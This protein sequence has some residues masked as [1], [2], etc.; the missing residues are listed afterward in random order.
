MTIADGER[1]PAIGDYGIV[2]DSR[3]CALVSRD[4]SIDW[5]CAPNFDSPSLFGRLLDWERGGFFRIAPVGPYEVRRGYISDTNVLETTF[6]A[7]GGAVA[8]IDFMPALTEDEKRATL[9]PLRAVLRIVEGRH[10]RVPMRMVY[11]PRS[12]YGRR[13]PNLRAHSLFEVTAS[14]GRDAVHLR[15]DVPLE[16]TQESASARFDAVAG[17]R[18]RFSLAYSEGEPGVILS[19]GYVDATFERTVAFWRDWSAGCTY[20]GPYRDN[21]VRSAL[22]LKLLSYAPSGAIVAAAT[23]SLPEGIGGAR[24]WD[25]RYCWLRDASFTIKAFL[26]LGLKREAEA[27]TGWLMHATRQSAPSLS[28]MYTLTGEPHIPERELRDLEGYRRSAP[29]RI[30]NAASGQHQFDVYGELIDAFH[31]YVR[32]TGD[33]VSADAASFVRRVADHV[34]EIWREPDSGIWEPRIAPL[35]YTHSKVMAWSALQHA[36]ALAEEGCIRGDAPRWRREAEEIRRTVMERGFNH[37][38]GAFTQTLDG[39]AVDAALLTL[40]LVEF[41]RPNDPQML[42]TITAIQSELSHN[43][44]LRRYL[45]DDGVEGGE[46][47]F[48]ICNFW[49]AAAL[50]RS[51]RIEDA[52]SVFTT[53]LEAQNDLGLMAEQIDPSTLAAL[54]N[55]PQAFSHIG[56]ITAALAIRDVQSENVTPS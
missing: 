40:P 50:A 9:Q 56:L 28:P 54:G 19:D 35:H 42:S 24:N 52:H 20:D 30:G 2:G 51:G 36:A 18:V 37:A 43:G 3:A 34:A 8:V 5:F 29:V 12:D 21:V 33:V 1:Y 4:G 23:T 55:V 11:Q 16:V 31:A 25:Y 46:G 6:V 39:D 45:V 48:L 27:F 49:L 10:G 22:A 38:R 47:A 26:S 17:E 53:T 32:D 14:R 41:I 15:S 13:T 7:G 44:F